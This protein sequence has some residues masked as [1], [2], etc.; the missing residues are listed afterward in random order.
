MRAAKILIGIAVGMIA[1]SV[2][3]QIAV[4]ELANMGLQEEMRDLA[5]Q[6]GAHVGFVPPS[7][8]EDARQSVILKAKKHGILLAPEQVTVVRKGSEDHATLSL[9]ADYSMPVSLGLFSFQ[10]HFTPAT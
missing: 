4:C 9:T 7:S 2:G 5:S 6:A 1:L 8:D 10:L 3:W